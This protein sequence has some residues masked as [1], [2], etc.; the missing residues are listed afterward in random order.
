MK[1]L[2]KLSEKQHEILVGSLL[3]DGCLY[4]G[5]KSINPCLCITRS[6]RDKQY[7]TWEANFF[8]EYLTPKSLTNKSTFDKR[9]Q[10][11]YY[12]S[13]LRTSCHPVFLPYYQAWYPQNQK[14]VPKDLTLSPLILAIWLADDGSFHLGRGHKHT[15]TEGKIYPSRI[16]IK[17]STH[18]FE[19]T[20]ISFLQ[21]LI[22]EF[23]AVSWSKYTDKSG[24]FLFLGRSSDA[25]KVIRLVDSIFPIGMERKSKLWRRR[26]ADIFDKKKI[27][28]PCKWCYSSNVYKNGHNNQSKQKYLC[29]DCGRQYV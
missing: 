29:K 19:E 12:S 10:K 26:E 28:P 20:D 25:K 14:R 15:K 4:L 18:G 7:L 5:P 17:L 16:N 11:T 3:G 27:R 9:T 2:A 13:R 1:S 22:E 24:T 8:K 6:K 23:T 21:D